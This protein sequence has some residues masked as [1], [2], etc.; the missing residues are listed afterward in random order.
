MSDPVDVLQLDVPLLIRLLEY[1]R[2]DA[3][4]DMDLHV[5]TENLLRNKGRALT[6]Q[7]Y[8]LLVSPPKVTGKFLSRAAAFGNNHV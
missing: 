4:T 7:D 3:E 5:L 2:E 8:D 1:A 6:M